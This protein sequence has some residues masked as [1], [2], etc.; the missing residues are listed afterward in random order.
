MCV[1]VPGKIVEI[2]GDTAKVD[3][4]GNICEANIK[5]VSAKIGDYVL[6]HA[7]CAIEVLKRTWRKKYCRFLMNLGRSK[8]KTLEAIKKE[9]GEYEGKNIKIMEV[10]GTHTSSIFKNG[11]RS[12][13]SPRIQLISGPAALY[14]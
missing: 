3:V 12:L 7:G 8:M 4:L 13:I 9:L 10:C 2:S 6:I 14:A 1:A 5:L 11:I